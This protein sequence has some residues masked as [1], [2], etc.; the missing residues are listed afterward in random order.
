MSTLTSILIQLDAR[1]GYAGFPSPPDDF[2]EDMTDVTQAL[3]QN[4]TATFSLASGRRLH[5]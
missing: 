2:L 4:P 1:S 3:V 5:D